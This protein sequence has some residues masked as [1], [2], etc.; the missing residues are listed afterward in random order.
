MVKAAPVAKAL[1]SVKKIC[2]AG[3]FV[4]FDEDGSFILNKSTGE[5]NWLRE[6]D[7]NYML[8]AWILPPGGSA[9]A[10]P[11]GFARQP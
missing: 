11:S 2:K 8:D 3:H 4:G 10:D 1:G 7:G 6:D 5:V 9:T